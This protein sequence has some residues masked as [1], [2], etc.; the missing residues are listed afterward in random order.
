MP[1]TQIQLGRA[2]LPR[3]PTLLLKLPPKPPEPI[4]T[5]LICLW[6]HNLLIR[7]HTNMSVSPNL[8]LALYCHPN[9]VDKLC[10]NTPVEHNPVAASYCCLNQKDFV[11]ICLQNLHWHHTATDKNLPHKY[12]T[13]PTRT[14]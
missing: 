11:P 2:L 5:M 8:S 6:N 13:V 3:P 9:P 7:P 10:A 12:C 14:C 4:S 1:V